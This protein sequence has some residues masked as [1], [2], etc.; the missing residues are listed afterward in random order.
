MGDSHSLYIER[1]GHAGND[2]VKTSLVDIRRRGG[3]S[4]RIS[5]RADCAAIESE[6]RMSSH[7]FSLWW[8]ASVV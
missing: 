4:R 8:Q 7:D 5:P 6:V 3:I 2:I 1:R